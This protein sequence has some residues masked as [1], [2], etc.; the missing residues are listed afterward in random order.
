MSD[1]L[2]GGVSRSAF[3]FGFREPFNR[4]G[5]AQFL[6]ER[7][8]PGGAAKWPVRRVYKDHDVSMTGGDHV[9]QPG[10]RCVA[11]RAANCRG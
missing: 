11:E 7:F 1:T 4:R 6:T 3:P 9:R 5:T 2:G 8:V 10:E